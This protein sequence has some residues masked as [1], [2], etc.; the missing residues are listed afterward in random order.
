MPQNLV[1]SE[2][3]MGIIKDE[4]FEITTDLQT[5]HIIIV[6][7]C[8]FIGDAKEEAVTTILDAAQYKNDGNLECLIVTGCLAER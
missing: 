5:A 1:D 8:A 7:T 4:G 6:N 2:I 3:M